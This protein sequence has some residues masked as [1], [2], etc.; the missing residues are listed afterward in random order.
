MDYGENL[1]ILVHEV[2][3]RS[4]TFKNKTDDWQIYH[5]AHHTSS[6]DL[7]IIA[8]KLKPKKLVLSTYYSGGQQEE[9]LLDDVKSN[10]DGNT[11]IAKDLMVIR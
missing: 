2:Y 10:F 8:N 7:G 11:I 3:S 6:I 1:D 5:S 9:S 4:E